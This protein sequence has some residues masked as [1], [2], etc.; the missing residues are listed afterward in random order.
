MNGS[1][2]AAIKTRESEANPAPHHRAMLSASALAAMPLSA[3]LMV[4]G[5]GWM[6]KRTEQKETSRGSDGIQTCIY[7]YIHT[8]YIYKYIFKSIYKIYIKRF[9]W[10]ESLV[11]KEL[12]VV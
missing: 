11:G 6:I 7:I 10:R 9:G 1:C 5:L 8:L 2:A 4:L 12:L 3:Y